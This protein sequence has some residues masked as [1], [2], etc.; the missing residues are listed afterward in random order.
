[1]PGHRLGGPVA[2]PTKSADDGY[3]KTL[4][5]E[6]REKDHSFKEH[7][8]SPIPWALR[9]DFTGLAYFPPNPK[10]RLR[11]RLQRHPTPEPVTMVT[12]KGI[13]RDML[14]WGYF[15]FTLDG[16]TRRLQAYKSVPKPG[17]HEESLFVPFRDGTSGK[18]SY[19]AARYLDLPVSRTDEY[20]LDFNLAYNPYCAYSDDYVCPFPPR[21]NWLD[22]RIEA[23]ERDFPLADLKEKL[24]AEGKLGHHH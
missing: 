14:K 1:M 5:F 18:E 20:V 4:E 6:R 7:P 13:P 2:P 3:I 17:E 8:Q 11:M 9:D 16:Q 21:E 15:E 12:S 10:F 24:S 19:G 23:G 22:I